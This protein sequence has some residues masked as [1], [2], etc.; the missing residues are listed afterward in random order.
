MRIIFIDARDT[1]S[2]TTLTL[3]VFV[4]PSTLFTSF[5]PIS[6]PAPTYSLTS[7][8]DCVRSIAPSARVMTFTSPLVF[9]DT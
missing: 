9:S 6:S 5:L 8:M 4:Q 2:S 3:S 7:E 1:L